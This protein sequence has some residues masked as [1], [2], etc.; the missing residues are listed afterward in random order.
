MVIYEPTEAKLNLFEAIMYEERIGMMKVNVSDAS[1]RPK[2]RN[3]KDF[4]SNGKCQAEAEEF[5]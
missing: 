3:E 5:K 4:R 2:G 1:T